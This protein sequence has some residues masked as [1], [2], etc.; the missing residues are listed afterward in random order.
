MS[1][2]V[3]HCGCDI[4][5]GEDGAM[6]VV[7]T[8]PLLRR[9]E[10]TLGS[11][12]PWLAGLVAAGWAL[13]AGA[14]LA[15]LPALVIWIGGGAADPIA[16]PAKTGATIWLAAH[17]V[18]LAMADGGT[19]QLAPGGLS[20]LILLLL[21]RAGRW[22]AHVTAAVEPRDVARILMPSVIG[23]AA[24][25]AIAARVADAAGLNATPVWAAAWSGAFA[26]MAM[27]AGVVREAPGF[28]GLAAAVPS[29]A[30]VVAFGAAG[31]V[32]ALLVVG[33]VLTAASIA[34]HSGEVGA[35]V[36]SLEPD[37]PG[38]IA[39]AG[40]N[41]AFAVNAIVWGTAYALGPGFSLG[42]G[43]VVSPAGID[44]GP[45]PVLPLLGGL[46]ADPGGVFGWLVLAGPVGAG[47]VGGALVWRNAAGVPR[48]RQ[49]ALG[50]GSAAGAGVVMSVLALMS[51]G[52]AGALRLSEIGPVPWQVALATITL[53]GPPAA[54][55]AA[56]MDG[57]PRGLL[58]GDDIDDHG[59]GA[60][61]PD[62]DG[63]D[64]PAGET[65]DPTPVTAGT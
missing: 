39:L 12:V 33:A 52:S 37:A 43:T 23:Y 34:L 21:Y 61:P 18:P 17:R 22:T 26:L 15:V 5:H 9:D 62:R 29:W 13:I 51:G 42:A 11:R 44:V 7:L 41:M 65:D 59:P 1:A 32:L 38:T 19:L 60:D 25:G 28:A 14:G 16:V 6:S 58:P 36:A 55:V 27:G 3:S 53:T 57:L 54:A 20:L 40:L 64:D 35:G 50:L 48:L 8:R 4:R 45:L 47:L 30:R 56:L 46:P 2:G 10:P 49:A 31:I 24:A 63:D